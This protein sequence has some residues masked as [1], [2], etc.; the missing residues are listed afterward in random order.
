MPAFPNHLWFFIDEL[1]TENN[2]ILKDYCLLGHYVVLSGRYLITFL[3]RNLLLSC[4]R[5]S[6][7][8]HGEEGFSKSNIFVVIDVRTS[9]LTQ[10][11]S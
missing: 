1:I 3:G 8:K 10:Y 6:T 2:E 5:S 9:N 7:L 4:S 11:G